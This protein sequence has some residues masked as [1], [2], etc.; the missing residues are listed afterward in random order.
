MIYALYEL[1][2]NPDIQE[3]LAEEMERIAD[4]RNGLSYD[5]INQ[6]EYLDMVISETLR[7]YPPAARTERL[8]QLSC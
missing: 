8:E 3:R 7:K 4:S 2:L 6:N 1:A 5:E